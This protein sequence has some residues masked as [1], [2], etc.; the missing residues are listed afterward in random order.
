MAIRM[1]IK[2]VADL[3]VASL[4]PQGMSRCDRPEFNS[5]EFVVPEGW[6]SRSRWH[7]RRRSGLQVPEKL[8]GFIR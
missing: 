7:F 1:P 2:I 8:S 5:A 3:M 6:P 4:P